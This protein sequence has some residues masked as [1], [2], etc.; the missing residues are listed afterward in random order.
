MSNISV[1]GTGSYVPNNII[2][3]DFLSTIVDTS[4]E[5]IRTRTGIL[6]RRI[7]KGEN[8]IYMA[9]ESAKEAIK[10]ANIDANDLDLI[11]VATLTP[12]NFMPSTAC[13]VQKEIGAMNALCFDISA[14]CS[15][16][17][18]GLE[19]A[20]SMLKNSFRN[21]ALIIGAENLSKIVDWEDRNTCVLFGDGAGAAILSKTEEEGILEFHSG[22]N[23][24]KGEHLTCGALK[25][26]NNFNKNDML[27]TNNF[28]KMNG[29][30]IF[31]FAVGAMSETI[32]NIQEKTKWDLNEIKY[33]ISHQAN[34]RIIEYT[35]KKLNTHKDKFYM[36][37]DKYGNTSAASIPIA[38]DE[39][40]KKGLLNKQD[41]IILVGFGGG[42]TFGGVAIVWSI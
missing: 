41:K 15:G 31:R 38:L 13:S 37:L 36:N 39:M 28:I 23:G 5:W 42:L 26:N 33:I 34:S 2:T 6:E 1:I 9:T 17:I 18:Y 24:L 29:K 22:S 7:S 30:E 20:C 19:I 16:F 40:N 35:A 14:A 27:E 21:K 12:D 32:C 3:N 8:T 10:N 11:I 4:D 25:S